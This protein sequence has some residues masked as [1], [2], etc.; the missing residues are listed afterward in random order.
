[1]KSL[2][3]AAIIIAFVPFT[4]AI[5]AELTSNEKEMVSA[6]IRNALTDPES[7]RFKW[8]PLIDER[9]SNIYCGVVNSK[10]RLGGYAGDAPYVVF[11]AWVD[12]TL[13][14]S[15]VVKIGNADWKSSA[16]TVVLGTCNDAGYSQLDLAG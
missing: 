3:I 8:V 14:A 16:S 2:I 11:L 4:A 12:G 6:S 1:M 15:I 13:K 9:K 5:G 10:N 7:A